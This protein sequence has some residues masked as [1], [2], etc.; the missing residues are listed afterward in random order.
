MSPLSLSFSLSP[1]TPPTSLSFSPRVNLVLGS[2]TAAQT[3]VI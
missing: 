3:G 1:P 2:P